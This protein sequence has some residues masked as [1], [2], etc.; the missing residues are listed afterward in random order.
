VV[1]VGAKPEDAWELLF[2]ARCRGRNMPEPGT[3]VEKYRTL[4]NKQIVSLD[5][6]AGR[7]K[8]SF[9]DR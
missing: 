6:Q 7:V 3:L 4:V 5:V 1:G 2:E 8:T 9:R